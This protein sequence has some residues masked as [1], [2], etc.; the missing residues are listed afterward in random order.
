MLEEEAETDDDDDEDL[1]WSDEDVESTLTSE[2]STTLSGESWPNGP[3]RQ[4]LPL[5]IFFPWRWFFPDFIQKQDIIVVCDV[6]CDGEKLG[7]ISKVW[8]C[9]A[10]TGGSIGGT[11]I[12]VWGCLGIPGCVSQSKGTDTTYSVLSIRIGCCCCPTNDFLARIF[13]KKLWSTW[14]NEIGFPLGK[15]F[16]KSIFLN[17][18][19]SL[20]TN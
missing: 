16:S 7:M 11:I 14:N 8:L 1:E 9:T 19:T 2:N 20:L 13:F 17:F 6:L 3:W 12:S 10:K 15:V 5:A 18:F 4:P